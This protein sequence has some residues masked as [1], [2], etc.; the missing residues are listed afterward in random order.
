MQFKIESDNNSNVSNGG[1]SN[2]NNNPL[3]DENHV[4]YTNNT[5]N[6]VF[7][8]GDSIVKNLNAYL[9]IENRKTRNWLRLDHSVEP[10]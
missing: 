10:R 3:R 9:L 4:R 6:A 8:I 5:R 7:I 2:N 1:N